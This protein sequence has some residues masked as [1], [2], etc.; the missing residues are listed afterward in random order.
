MT[1]APMKNAPI[2]LTIRKLTGSI[3]YSKGDLVTLYLRNAPSTD[4]AARKTNS[5]L[6]IYIISTNRCF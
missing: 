4:P 6:F 2:T 5:K 3:L 1:N